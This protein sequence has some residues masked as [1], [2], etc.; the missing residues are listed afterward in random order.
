MKEK[1]YSLDEIL[2]RCA[3]YNIILASVQ[4]VKVTVY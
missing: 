1:Y 3:D 2:K 4:M